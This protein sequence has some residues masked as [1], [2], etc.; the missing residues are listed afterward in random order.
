MDP[1]GAAASLVAL[2]QISGQVFNLCQSYYSG[3]K[4]ARE[5]I[6][7]LR[8][9]VTA[10]QDVL[11]NVR[12]LAETPGSAELSILGLL[13][14]PDGLIQQ[15]QTE[16]KELAAKLDTGQGK[17][18]MRQF[19]LRALRW[20]FSKKDVDKSLL[21]IRRQKEIFNLALTADTMQVSHTEFLQC[22]L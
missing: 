2:I 8:N 7:R 22:H 20:P 14:Q 6:C 15:C 4:S 13:N 5:D 11:T 18:N 10:L 9:E 19:G 12:D 21:V 17:D 3:V 16:L 1:V